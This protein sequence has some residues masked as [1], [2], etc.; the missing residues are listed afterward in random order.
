MIGGDVVLEASQKI[1]TEAALAG[2][3]PCQELALQ[4]MAEEAL[5]QV[6]GVGGCLARPPG[7]GIERIPI[8]AAKLGQGRLRRR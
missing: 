3:G 5:G 8:G 7:I 2:L 1:R 4:E 6:L